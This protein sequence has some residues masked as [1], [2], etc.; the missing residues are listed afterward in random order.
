[1]RIAALGRTR[2]LINSI[3]RLNQ[4]GYDVV[5]IGTCKASPEY[6]VGPEDFMSL[7]EELGAEYFNNVCINS[8]EVIEILKN[9][10]ADIAI[11][12]NWLTLI[13]KEAIASFPMGILNA[14]S[15]DLPR[16]RGNACPNWAIIQ[17]E[18]KI[19]V[20]IHL[21]DPEGVDTGP[22]LLKRYMHLHNSTSIGEVYQ[23]LEAS[24]PEM[25]LE[26]VEA[27][28]SG[29]MT[30][31]PQPEEPSLALRCYPRIPSDS[32]INWMNSAVELERLVRASSE[33]FGGTYTFVNKEKLIIW[34]AHSDL[35]TYPSLAVPGQI[36]W[37][38]PAEG[39]VGVATGDG[40]LVL[41][42]VQLEDGVRDKASNILKSA[43]IR[44][45][46]SLEDEIALLNKRL[47]TI[48]K[49]LY[50]GK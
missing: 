35:F 43:R 50:E 15:G 24:I 20:T 31:Q 19:A 25:F 46:M 34:R 29:T 16:Y 7:A 36:V 47:C 32:R 22:I 27:L 28:S 41:D 9:A 49:L 14:H 45:G 40:V 30:P 38:L 5:L 39:K 42:E 11:S 13:G 18:E 26:T 3:R 48:E 1:M 8:S 10:R 6:G 37:R 44:L 21:M 33:P 17:E 23:F 12:I 2:M 4:T